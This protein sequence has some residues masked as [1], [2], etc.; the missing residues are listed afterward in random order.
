M[1]LLCWASLVL[2][3]YWAIRM[4]M[5]SLAHDDGDWFRARGRRDELEREKKSLLKAIKEI[6]FDREIGKISTA[7]ATELV[8]GYRA[9][10][11]EVIKAIE[12]LDDN[13]VDGR[14]V[15]ER[16]AAEVRARAAVDAKSGPGKPTSTGAPQQP[17][18][19]A[20][21]GRP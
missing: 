21:P 20:K 12:Q 17:G 7:D 14:S 4:A 15:R 2:T 5:A 9:K 1:M 19:D 18:A 3:G 10:A 11:I 13:R 8:A 16:I 6:D